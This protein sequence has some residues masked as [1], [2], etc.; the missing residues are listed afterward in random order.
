M[1]IKEKIHLEK[2]W[3]FLCLWEIIAQFSVIKTAAFKFKKKK[4]VAQE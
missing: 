3:F 2:S 4:K 1:E